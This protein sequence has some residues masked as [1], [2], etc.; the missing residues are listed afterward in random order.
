M[1]DATAFYAGTPFLSAGKQYCTTTA[2]F[3]E[4]RHIKKSFAA[5]E[6][7][8]DAGILV[9]MDPDS[10]N[11]EL[12]T[13]TAKKT[14]D[15]QKL[16]QQDISVLALAKQLD[17]VLVSDDYA[18]A[19]VAASM[20]IAVQS[21]SGKGIKQVRKWISYCS[22]CGMA[23]GPDAKECRLCGNKLKRRYKKLAQGD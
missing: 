1:L 17:A 12:A 18:V 14:G 22:A 2:V 8:M 11:L 3:D 15:H 5:L 16:S 23:F 20:D 9:L 21:S 4:V 19:N 10:K 13:S 7:L 6:A